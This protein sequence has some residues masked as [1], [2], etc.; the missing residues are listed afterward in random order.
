MT[1]AFRVLVPVDDSPAALR[2]I[3]HVIELHRHGLP[4]EVHLLNVQLPLRG[5]APA[6]IAQAALDDY[7]REEGMKVLAKAR[8]QLEQAGVPVHLHVGVGDIGSTV[9]AFAKRL[10]CLQ[11]VMGTRGLGIVA[12]LMLGSVAHHVV[13]ES[14]IPVTLLHA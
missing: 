9:L 13:T 5:T 8:G 3:G 14:D 2:A 4:M 6:L 12:G 7:H 10:G 1:T 11:I